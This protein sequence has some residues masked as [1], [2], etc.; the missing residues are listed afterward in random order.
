MTIRMTGLASGLDTESMITALTS[1]Y[2]TNVDDLKG[3]QKKLSWTQDKWKSLNNDITAFY[4]GTLADMRFSTAYNKKITTASNTSAVTVVTGDAAMNVSQ[5]LSVT[6][7]AATAYMTGGKLALASGATATS[8]TSDTTMQD[9]GLTTDGTLKIKM[10]VTDGSAASSDIISVA[11]NKTDKISDVISRI[12]STAASSSG[13]KIQANFDAANGRIYMGAT[14]SGKTASFAIDSTND[15]NLLDSLGLGSSG[16][17]VAGADAAIT[18]NGVEYTSKSNIFTVNGLTITA[19]QEASDI[20]LTTKQDTSG[21]YDTIKAFLKSYNTLV[22]NFDTLY[23]ADSASKYNMLTDDEKDKMTDDEVKDWE[24]KIKASL[25]RNDETLGTLKDSMRM[26][27]S[28]SFS[29]TDK[30]GNTSDV[31]LSTFGINTLSY[32]AAEEN[33][34]NAFHIDGDPDDSSTKGNTDL[35]SA[36]I[37]TDPDKVA[38]FFTQLSRTLYSKMSDLMKSTEYS[39]SFTIYEDKLMA[40]QYSAYTD[41]INDAQTELEEKQDYYYTKFS[42]METALTKLQSSSSS[43]SSLFGTS[44]S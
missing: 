18:L 9:L 37:A 10:G 8:I 21:I 42:K 33:E 22:N 29:V 36:A 19:N 39:S 5:K 44:S 23:N 38:S 24:D 12:N 11:V 26:V 1:T 20:T 40:S 31:L 4:N 7:L 2:Q 15:S 16:N 43:L 34:R 27:L 28:Q 30:D 6:Q 17:Y 25:L 32:F 14:D 3:Q 13:N 41:K 35:L